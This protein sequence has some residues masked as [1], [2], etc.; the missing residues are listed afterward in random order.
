MSQKE[1]RVYTSESS[2][3]NPFQ[4]IREIYI[5]FGEGRF[6][7]RRLYIRNLREQYRQSFLGLF[8]AF[9]P[10]LLNGLVWVLLKDQDVV[11]LAW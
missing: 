4:I 3:K 6:L 7:A 9:F 10:P 1:V 11:S 5:G 8:W 2:V